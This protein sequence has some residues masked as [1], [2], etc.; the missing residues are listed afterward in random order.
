MLSEE[1]HFRQVFKRIFG[2]AHSTDVLHVQPL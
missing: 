2:L 1:S